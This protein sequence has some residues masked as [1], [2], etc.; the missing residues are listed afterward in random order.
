M[1][2]A[3]WVTDLVD[4]L[5]PTGCAACGTWLPGG[6][7]RR[8]VCP[9]CRARLRAAPWPRCTRCHYPSGTGRA[10]PVRCREC[11]A[12]PD[13]L[14][15]ARYAYVLEPPASDLVHA[16]KYGG[17]PELADEMG[18]GMAGL[19]L[20]L[21]RDAGAP[22]VVPVPTTPERVRRRGYNQ[23]ELLARSVAARA[24]WSVSNALQR[25]HSGRTQVALH[26]SQRKANVRG[27]FSARGEEVSRVRGAQVVLVDDVLTTGATAGAAA[28]ELVRMGARAVTLVTFARAL[29]FRHR[30]R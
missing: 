13:E 15:A 14:S 16:L 23:A 8:L 2:T 17:W 3:S 1:S 5:L 24:G 28:I 25:M 29:P 7:G 21:E 9:R 6:A 27:V 30:T 19:D 22:V 26:P 10:P 12:W 20:P 18:A 4:L 11:A